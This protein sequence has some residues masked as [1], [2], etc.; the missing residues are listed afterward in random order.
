MSVLG[1]IKPS[2]KVTAVSTKIAEV[3]VKAYYI[4]P[5]LKE[6]A[7]VKISGDGVTYYYLHKTAIGATVAGYYVV[8]ESIKVA[9]DQILRDRGMI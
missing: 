2:V 5:E 6:I 8:V 4:E 9:T 1:V 3:F 7:C